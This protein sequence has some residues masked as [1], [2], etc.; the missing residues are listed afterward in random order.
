VL[1]VCE[2][3]VTIAVVQNKSFT[4]L[5]AW[6]HAI[7]KSLNLRWRVEIQIRFLCFAS[8][9]SLEIPVVTTVLVVR[10]ESCSVSIVIV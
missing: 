4:L 7:E 10:V 9:V 8:K 3:E 6:K 2:C 5:E 1:L